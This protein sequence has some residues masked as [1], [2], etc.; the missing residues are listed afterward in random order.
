MPALSGAA[1]EK[2]ADEL[3]W[4]KTRVSAALKATG[5]SIATLFFLVYTITLLPIKRFSPE[6]GKSITAEIK[7][8]EAQK[9]PEQRCLNPD[10]LPENIFTSFS[11]MTN[12]LASAT[13]SAYCGWRTLKYS[14]K[15]AK[16]ALKET[17]KNLEKS[18]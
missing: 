11:H 6:T 4:D 9:S 5:G 2:A 3:S 13:L 16:I 15:Q 1:S 12:T 8:I 7:K 18:T 17:S 14:I 10:N